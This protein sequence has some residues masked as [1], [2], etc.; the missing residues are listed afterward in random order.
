MYAVPVSITSNNDK[1]VALR[2]LPPSVGD[3]EVQKE[4]VL[5]RLREKATDLDRYEVSLGSSSDVNDFYRCVHAYDCSILSPSKP[6]TKIC[7]TGQLS[8]M[9]AS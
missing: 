3:V 7:S 5:K 6:Q 1:M 8:T 2:S 9:Y 4:R